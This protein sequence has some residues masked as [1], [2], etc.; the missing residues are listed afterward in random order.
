MRGSRKMAHIDQALRHKPTSGNGFAD[1]RPVP[2]SLAETRLNSVSL[3][4]RIGELNLS[5]PIVINAMTGGA[6]ET[7]QINRELAEAAATCGLAMAVGSQM[8]AIKDPGVRDSYRIVRKTHP[9]GVLFANLGTE[10]TVEQAQ[11]AVDMLEADALQIHLNMMQELVMPEGDRDF[12][13]ASKRIEAIVRGVDVPVVV[14]EVGFG[15]TAESALRLRELGVRFLDV[16][17]RGGTDF[18]AIENAR[19]ETP[20]DFLREGWGCPTVISLLESARYY[21][22]QSLVASGGIATGLNAVKAL[23]IGASAVGMAGS[24]LR[25]Q[26]QRGVSG[27]IGHIKQIEEEVRI[28]MAALGALTIAELWRVPVVI[29]G[30]TGNWCRERGIDTAAYARRANR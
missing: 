2:L 10:A 7:E 11:A 18:S 25:V 20:Y 19:R 17:G 30:E 1:I 27:L 15:L 3:A 22:P 12:T 6:Q 9:K 29:G 8:A 14:K 16:G 4:T 28:L 24:L 5:S 23:I 13:G 21:P 26:Q